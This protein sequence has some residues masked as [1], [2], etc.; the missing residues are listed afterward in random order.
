LLESPIHEARA[1]GLAIMGQQATRK[2]NGAR[3]E[4][5]YDF[6]LRRTDRI[7]N[8][9]L[10]DIS[11]HHVVGGY[12]FDKPR[13]VLYELARSENL[14]QRRI[15]MFST[16]HFVR[17]GDLDDTFK[18]AAILVNDK[19]DL[20]HKVTGGMLR[21]AGKRDRNRLQRFLDEHAATAPRVLL[22][23]AIEHLDQDER[24]HYMAMKGAL[25]A[26]ATGRAADG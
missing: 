16:M 25:E 8:W 23:Y 24:R 11:C 2:S 17:K 13:D 26:P 21:E 15:A 19:H 5:L 10:V 20:I 22:R 18:I 1:G 7:N 14:W 3:K 12:L 6:Y 9:D 4:D